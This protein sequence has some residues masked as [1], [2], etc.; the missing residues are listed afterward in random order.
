[1]GNRGSQGKQ[2]APDSHRQEDG[3][4]VGQCGVSGDS[5]DSAV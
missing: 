3:G 2:E 1:M 5:D 4:S